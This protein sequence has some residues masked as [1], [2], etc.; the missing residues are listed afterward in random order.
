MSKLVKAKNLQKEI[1]NTKEISN[2]YI[3]EILADKLVKSARLGK[4]KL[5]VPI[6]K[7]QPNQ[8]DS[9]Y[10]LKS[11][12]GNLEENSITPE[13]PELKSNSKIKIEVTE[14]VLAILDNFGYKTSIVDSDLV[15]EWE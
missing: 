2:Y 15:V 6:Q 10:Y 3:E 13:F 9:K 1:R 14:E 8:V 4:T 5:L 12:G 11:F 7:L